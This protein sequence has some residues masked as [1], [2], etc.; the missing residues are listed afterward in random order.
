MV[1]PGAQ[2]S[3]HAPLIHS[4]ICVQGHPER[5]VRRQSQHPGESAAVGLQSIGVKLEGAALTD[6]QNSVQVVAV[7]QQAQGLQ[8]CGLSP[9]GSPRLKPSLH[10]EQPSAGTEGRVAL[11]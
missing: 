10:G 9:I 5:P 11:D 1:I 4:A 2:V 8:T 7:M 6:I 3:P